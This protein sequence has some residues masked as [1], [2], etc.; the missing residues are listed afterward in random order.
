MKGKQSP[1]TLRSLAQQLKVHVSTVS[2][3][4]NGTDDDARNAAAPE[5][6]ER[7]RE[8]ARQLNYRP[9]PH[10]IGLRT[11][12][13]R[14][15]SVL[16]PQL[17]DLVVATIYEG[18]D[19]AAADSR[20]LTF[21]ANTG[22]APPRQRQLGEMALD[23]RVEGLIFADA[24][25]DDTRFLD[26]I[27]R[28]GVPMV[29]VSRH[30]GT[31]CA[32]T[33]DDVAGGRMAAEHLLAL[34]H[35]DIAVL[36]GEQYAS[37]GCDRSAGFIAYCREQGVDIPAKWILHGP[38][39]TRAGRLAGEKLFRNARKPSAVFAV[40]DFLAIGLMGAVR[41]RGLRAGH[42]VAIVGFND[43]PLAAELP[44]SLT[45]I[46]SPMHA[47][48]YRSMELLLERIKGGRPESERLAPQL[49]VRA[50]TCPRPGEA[51]G[52]A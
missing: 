9:N 50:S 3:V 48:G 51:G 21:V 35:R 7:I 14:T 22:D 15:V 1:V 23:R 31:H 25:R 12:K 33:C 36:A 46:R 38:F 42:D 16:V 20:Y 37:T 41:D 19:A 18:I 49:M 28:R 39:D 4:L 40:N 47:M 29:L 30:L 52:L 5:T 27:A 34:G 17:S 6:V 2:R 13:T 24:R 45:T 8:L 32:V 44:I 43:T 11:Q 10:A 26:E